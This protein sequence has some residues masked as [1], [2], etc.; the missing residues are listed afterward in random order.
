LVS[1]SALVRCSFGHSNFFFVQRGG[2]VLGF[3]RLELD[4]AL[5]VGLGGC[6]AHDPQSGSFGHAGLVFVHDASF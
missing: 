1:S 4:G 5:T 6:A 2:E 3:L